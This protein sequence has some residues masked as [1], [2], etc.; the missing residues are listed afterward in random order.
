MPANAK[1]DVLETA[2]PE[3]TAPPSTGRAVA[4][5]ARSCGSCA[6]AP[7]TAPCHGGAFPHARGLWSTGGFASCKDPARALGANDGQA[8]STPQAVHWAGVHDVSSCWASGQDSGVPQEQPA[9]GRVRERH[10]R[11]P[12]KNPA[13]P[14]IPPMANQ[15]PMMIL[16]F[17]AIVTWTKGRQF[18]RCAAPHGLPRSGGGSGQREGAAWESGQKGSVLGERVTRANTDL[19]FPGH[20]D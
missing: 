1:T 13:V 14:T 9:S 15:S 20:P 10:S 11:T 6:L 7:R 19:P 3:F 8:A 18:P 16:P 17:T 5:G 4:P 12:R 2:Y